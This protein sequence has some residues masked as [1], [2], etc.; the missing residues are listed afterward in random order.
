MLLLLLNLVLFVQRLGGWLSGASIPLT[1]WSKFPPPVPPP[2]HSLPLPLELGPLIAARDSGG[3]LQLPQRVWSEPCRQTVFGE[4]QAKN[5]TS[6]SND[7][8][9]L[10]GSALIINA[11]PRKFLHKRS[12]PTF[13]HGAFAPWFIWSRRPCWL[14]SVCPVCWAPGFVFSCQTCRSGL[15]PPPTV[16]TRAAAASGGGRR[17]KTYAWSSL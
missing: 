7:L 2:L 10:R 4:F 15:P 3:A 17:T 13:F 8:Q 11:L 16:N 9:E 1:P 14:L 12:P 6:S 5:L